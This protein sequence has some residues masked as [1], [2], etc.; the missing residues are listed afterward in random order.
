MPTHLTEE[1]L[2][3]LKAPDLL[4]EHRTAQLMMMNPM[5]VGQ[6]KHDAEERFRLAEQEVN[7]R[8]GIFDDAK[9]D[10]R[11]ENVQRFA[12]SATTVIVNLWTVHGGR[13]MKEHESE[14]FA[15]TLFEFFK[16]LSKT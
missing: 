4:R 13:E 14:A 1:Q 12:H 3:T 9:E 8:C 5:L 6:A 11:V 2:N 7:R 16:E 10:T 15:R